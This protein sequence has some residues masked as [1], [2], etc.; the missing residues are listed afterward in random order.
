MKFSRNVEKPV[1]EGRADTLLTGEKSVVGLGSV[2]T[3]AP[4]DVVPRLH[5]LK[6]D[7]ENPFPVLFD[8][9]AIDE[10]Q[11]QGRPADETHRYTMQYVLMAPDRGGETKMLKCPLPGGDSPTVPSAVPAFKVADW[12]ERE[13]YDMFG[14]NF[15]GH[16]NMS[17]ILMPDWWKGHPLRKEHPGRATE[18][19][20][21]VISEDDLKGYDAE[22]I[23][24]KGDSSIRKV[25]EVTGEE[26]MILNLGP[27]HPGTHGILRVV[28]RL[29]GE[30]MEKVLPVIGYHHRGAEKIAE[31]QTFHTYIPYC[32]RIDYLGG[33][34]NELPYV[35]A[36]EQLADVRVPER[37]TM[38]RVM[39]AEIYRICNHLVWFGT[40]GHDVGAMT[41]VFYTFRERENLF[42][43]VEMITGGRMHP[44]FLRIG[45]CSMDLPDGWDDALR[46]FLKDFD[47][48]LLEYD[49]LLLANPIFKSRTKGVGVMSLEEC[50]EWGV[51]G[52]NLR[53]SGTAFDLRKA[54]PYCGYETF[55][56]DIPTDTAG[57]CWSRAACRHHEM[58]ESARIIRQC[59]DRMPGGDYI[60]RDNRYAF[61][62]K[63]AETM[64]DIEAL[65]NHFLA[66]GWG[67]DL[68]P[69]E[70]FQAVEQPKGIGAYHVVSD[71][72]TSPYRLRI[73]A[74]SFAH[75]QT[76]PALCEGHLLSDLLSVIGAMDYVL[77]DVDR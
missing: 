61:P 24:S 26:T 36:C 41:P 56:F 17:R 22:E 38:I 25:D 48:H 55:D 28:L 21:L 37:A 67:L 1:W 32:D 64:M 58:A 20:P 5:A 59:V 69:G 62:V 6:H 16:P 7:P 40:L 42:K 29:N 9:T 47:K 34:N 49:T 30:Y 77:A 60:S 10:S 63:K 76:L 14:I 13:V 8:V 51:T 4:E 71:G 2:E 3:I 57:D 52:P 50:W 72:R 44:N 66:V 54:A 35:M 70:S 18:M 31:R 74:P 27:N 12:Y 73:R 45:G 19:E 15:D 75:M 53:A 68:P 43:V 65:I 23:F 46:V 33:T 11:R 39:L